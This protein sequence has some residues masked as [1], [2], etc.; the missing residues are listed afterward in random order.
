MNLHNE[1]YIFILLMVFGIIGFAFYDVRLTMNFL[2]SGVRFVFESKV[3]SIILINL[4]F[5]GFVFFIVH[6]M[7]HFG[8]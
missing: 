6:R 2:V 1:D 7:L 8:D 3:V 4:G 5:A